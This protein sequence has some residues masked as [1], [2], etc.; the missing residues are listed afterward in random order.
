MS[1]NPERNWW[2]TH[3]VSTR[4]TITYADDTKPVQL[5]QV[6]GF[7]GELR[8]GVQRGGQFGF[9]SMPLVGA[10][11][12]VAWQGGHRATGAAHAVEDPRYRPTGLKPGESLLYMVDKAAADGSGGTMRRVL[13]GLL[14]WAVSLFGKTI[15][16]GT[17][18][19]T[20]VIVITGAA[21]TLQGPV[22]IAGDLTVSGTTNVQDIAIAGSESGGGPL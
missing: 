3:G 10:Q 15:N 4:M 1:D 19:D 7:P 2:R 17:T 20:Q 21:I 18:A 14:G 11:A 12:V 5:L 8:P 22:K 9:S 6:E 13:E 16:I